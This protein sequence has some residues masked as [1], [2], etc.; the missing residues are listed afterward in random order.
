MN[1]PSAGQKATITVNSID[2]STAVRHLTCLSYENCF[3]SQIVVDSS[4]SGP[5]TL[6]PVT[7]VVLQSNDRAQ[8][9]VAEFTKEELRVFIDQLKAARCTSD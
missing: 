8:D 6:K 2:Y 9:L 1:V 4:R 3:I 7:R 5:N